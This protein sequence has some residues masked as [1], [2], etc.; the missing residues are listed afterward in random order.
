MFVCPLVI[1]CRSKA[2]EDV[3]SKGTSRLLACLVSLW[4]K[5]YFKKL[6]IQEFVCSHRRKCSF[7]PRKF[8]LVWDTVEHARFLQPIGPVEATIQQIELSWIWHWL[9]ANRLETAV[10]RLL[11]AAS[12]L[13]AYSTV[14][15]WWAALLKTVLFSL[16]LGQVLSSVTFGSFMIYYG[17]CKERKRRQPLETVELR[18]HQVSSDPSAPPPGYDFINWKITELVYLYIIF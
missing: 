11:Y 1:A 18:G 4:Q 8:L 12:V 2:I 9:W 10:C 7:S 5:L 6:L 15:S 16:K 17:W 3:P 13:D 14:Y